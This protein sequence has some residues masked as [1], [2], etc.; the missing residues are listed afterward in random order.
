MLGASRL[1]AQTYEQV[2]ADRTSTAGAVLVVVAASIAAGLGSGARDL[3]SL[4]GAVLVLL[5]T[6]MIW[7]GLTYVIGTRLLPEPQ[8][9]SS[10]GEVLRTTGF[11]ASPGVLR[12]FGALPSVGLPIFLGV[13]VWMLFTFVVAIRQALDYASSGRALAVCFLGWAIHALVF[14]AFVLVAI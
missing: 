14:F 13:T 12:I 11:S 1:D 5:M 7:V 3:A 8:T 6:W 4:A 2:E 10:I 9:H